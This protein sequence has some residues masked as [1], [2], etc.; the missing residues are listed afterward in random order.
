MDSQSWHGLSNY[1]CLCREKCTGKSVIK[2]IIFPQ[3]SS[4]PQT[5]LTIYTK[6][7]LVTGKEKLNRPIK[8]FWSPILGD[9]AMLKWIKS[10]IL[11]Q[12]NAKKS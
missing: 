11:G 2:R 1:H 4:Q 6:F 12:H 9:T 10:K 3:K 8:S 7:A 5:A